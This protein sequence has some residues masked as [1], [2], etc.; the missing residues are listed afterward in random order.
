MDQELAAAAADAPADAL[1]LLTSRQHFSGWND[2]MASSYIRL[3]KRW[4][5]ATQTSD[6]ASRKPRP[7]FTP[8]ALH[9][10][11]SERGVYEISVRSMNIDDRPTT[12]LRAYLHILGKLQ[13]A[14]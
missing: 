9:S 13:M 3:T 8:R 12:D 4:Q 7:I 2:V 6:M 10:W 11:R 5:T 14:I 1:C